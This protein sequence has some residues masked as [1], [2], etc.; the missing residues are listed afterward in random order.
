MLEKHLSHLKK[1]PVGL[2]M[3]PPFGMKRAVKSDDSP[4]TSPATASNWNSPAGVASTSPSNSHMTDDQ[5]FQNTG[6]NNNG[7]GSN[8]QQPQQ[9]QQ[10]MY[11]NQQPQQLAVPGRPQ[12]QQHR[13]NISD[14]S[15][16]PMEMAGDAKRQQMSAPGQG[17]QQ[18][19]GQQ[20]QQQPQLQQPIPQHILQGLPQ[21]LQRPR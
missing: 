13:R 16:G 7:M 11:G 5:Y 4:S 1:N 3:G 10:Q 15:G 21:Q 12:Q 20:I 2:D 19:F 17:L 8:Q 18:N 14:I 6:F 9:Q